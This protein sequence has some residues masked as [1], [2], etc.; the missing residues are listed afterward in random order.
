[1][2]GPWQ[3]TNHRLGASATA[4]TG[5]HFRPAFKSIRHQHAHSQPPPILHQQHP[6]PSAA[7][8]TLHCLPPIALQAA[9]RMRH[10]AS[11]GCGLGAAAACWRLTARADGRRQAIVGGQL[12]R[13]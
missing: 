7:T 4:T 3:P 1:M 11:H 9:N 13:A 6:P 12:S 10:H 5:A 8:V 2:L